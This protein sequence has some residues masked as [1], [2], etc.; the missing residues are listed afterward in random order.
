MKFAKI[1]HVLYQL[2]VRAVE[3]GVDIN[4]ILMHEQWRLQRR[5]GVPLL[6]LAVV[7]LEV[8]HS[9]KLAISQFL[10]PRQ[11]NLK[12]LVIL[13]KVL[14]V[15]LPLI[16]EVGQLPFQL[17]VLLKLILKY[18]I[19]LSYCIPIVLRFLVALVLF[20]VISEE[21]LVAHVALYPH[22]RTL[23]PQMLPR[24]RNRIVFVLA[25]RTNVLLLEADV[26]EVIEKLEYGKLLSI[27][28][29]GVPMTS[30]LLA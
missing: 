19:L 3:T 21:D 24:V 2:I 8:I 17:L 13:R 29:L 4:L 9:Q 28:A 18:L 15:S 11:L 23:L 16:F 25:I 27:V 14:I 10:Q 12:I 22:L 26:E 30:L 20:E 5:R 6:A 7:D 1:L